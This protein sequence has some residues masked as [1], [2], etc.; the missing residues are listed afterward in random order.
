MEITS[1]NDLA[2][3]VTVDGREY[4]LP[5]QWPQRLKNQCLRVEYCILR[6]PLTGR[7]VRFLL[8]P[9]RADTSAGP[10]IL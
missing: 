9:G 2:Y 7:G 6:T 1:Y 4:V 5:A 3:S 8:R 10:A